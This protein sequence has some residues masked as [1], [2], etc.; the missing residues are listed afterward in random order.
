MPKKKPKR[1]PVS[2][3]NEDQRYEARSSRRNR[4]VKWASISIIVALVMSLLAAAISVA[5]SSAQ[6]LSSTPTPTAC[7]EIDTDG[8]G[9]TNSI[10]SD[11]DGDGTVN[12]LDDDIDG[13]GLLNADDSDPAATNCGANAP[14]PVLFEE[15]ESTENTQPVWPVIFVLVAAAA[16]YLVL[17][18]L[19][20][21]RK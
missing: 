10:D 18:R 14:L 12:G 13:D 9:Q 20:S 7:A 19:R 17:R 21:K 1:R 11:I 3:M 6:M 5:P 4:M 16:G 15:K 8:D 2:V